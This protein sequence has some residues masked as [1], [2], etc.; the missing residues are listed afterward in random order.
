MLQH[1]PRP[2]PNDLPR[3]SRHFHALVY[4]GLVE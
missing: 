4:Q 1:L 2:V 3:I